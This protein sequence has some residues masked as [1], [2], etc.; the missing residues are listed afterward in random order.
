MQVIVLFK[1]GLAIRGY[2]YGASAMKGT[3]HH[4]T[5]WCICAFARSSEQLLEMSY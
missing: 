4:Q 5:W 1:Q 3:S 2:K